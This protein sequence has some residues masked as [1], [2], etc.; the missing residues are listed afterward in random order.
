MNPGAFERHLR[1]AIELNRRRAPLYAAASAG[2]SLGLSR[3]LIRWE[4]ALLPFARW[5]DGRAERYRRGNIGLL[6]DLFVPMSDVLPFLARGD[7]SIPSLPP[8]NPRAVARPLRR[9]VRE[10]GLPAAIPLI[11]A[12]LER[13]ANDPG[14]WCMLRH[15]LESA[16]RVSYYSTSH[17]ERARQAGLPSPG[18]M[19]RLLFR[20]HLLGLPPAT[21][22][23]IR[24]LA[25]Q[26]EGI[27][28]LCRDLPPIPLPARE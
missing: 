17:A 7:S 20:L 13:L 25:L 8:P 27:P 5:L 15:L 21:R 3:R 9:A 22:L 24:A 2:A 14:C 28:I 4:I 11:D 6:D 18:W 1:E 16:R 23:D 10:R 19:H 26:R 12:E